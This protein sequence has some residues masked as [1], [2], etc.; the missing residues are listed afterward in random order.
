MRRSTV[1]SLPLQLVFPGDTL[2][3]ALATLGG[4][5]RIISILCRAAQGD[6]GKYNR[7]TSNIRVSCRY[8]L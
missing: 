6:Q 2:V 1:L 8:S 3:L 4:G 7:Y 5:H